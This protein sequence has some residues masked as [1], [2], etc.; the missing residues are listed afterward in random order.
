MSM[1][2][3]GSAPRQYPHRADTARHDDGVILQPFPSNV[4]T[5]APL[6]PFLMDQ[7]DD[8]RLGAGVGSSFIHSL[9][10]SFIASQIE[11]AQLGLTPF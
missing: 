9:I 7:N 3:T 6:F 5:E 10:Y 4:S 1:Y 8:A 2:E 11:Y